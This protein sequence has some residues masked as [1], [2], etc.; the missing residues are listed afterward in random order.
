MV[1][2]KNYLEIK[3]IQNKALE[4]CLYLSMP[5]AVALYLGSAPIISSLFGYGSFD[6]KSVSNTAMAL[7]IFSFGLPAFAMQKI[8]VSFFFVRRNT[9]IPFYITSWAVMLNILINVIFLRK[10][11]I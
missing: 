11:D 3:E 2:K 5:A 8:F 4:L 1:Y 7:Y 9:K 10:L 6:E